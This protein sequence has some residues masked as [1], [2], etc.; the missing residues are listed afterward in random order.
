MAIPILALVS[1]L[2]VLG[3][4]LLQGLRPGGAP[5]R[6]RALRSATHKRRYMSRMCMGMEG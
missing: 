3:A 5:A 2:P 4:G 1:A 6:C